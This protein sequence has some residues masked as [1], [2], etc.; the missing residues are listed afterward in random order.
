MAEAHSRFGGS[1]AA[2]YM[3]C[4]G[5]VALNAT[6]PS[7]PPSRYALEGNYVHEWAALLLNDG[8][9]SA[10][11]WVGEMLPYDQRMKYLPLKGPDPVITPI[12]TQPLSAEHARALNHYLDAVWEEFD[13]HPGA[14]MY[15]EHGFTL[16]VEGCEPGEVFG[17]V[18]CAIYH[19]Q[20]QRLVGFDLK[21]GYGVV[22]AADNKQLLFYITALV[23]SLRLTVMYIEGVI[24]QPN[25]EDV[26][27]RGAH[28]VKRTTFDLI[29]LHTFL[30]D[31]AHA[32]QRAK[33]IDIVAGDGHTDGP[34]LLSELHAGPHCKFCNAGGAGVCPA[35]E[36]KALELAR[37]D[38]QGVAGVQ[39]VQLPDPATLDP[40][41]LAAILDA[42]D[43][44]RGWFS[45]VER[46][47]TDMAVAKQLVIPGRKVVAKQ[48]RA[49]FVEDELAIAAYVALLYGIPDQELRPP[50]LV[51]ITAMEKLINAYVQGAEERKAAKADI[52]AKFTVRESSGYDLVPLSDKRDAVDA[53]AADFAGVNVDGLISGE[54][55]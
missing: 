2:R 9:R 32:I 1:T 34:S 27:L 17:T 28:P 19:P 37:L 42:I 43:L 8:A 36:K 38:F 13:R 30:A 48:A 24:V 49:K 33:L 6:V 5:S 15:V 46:Y 10:D 3:A 53:V 20:A 25:G 50:S 41:R 40:Q 23:Q 35:Q 18:D 54:T 12:F 14:I 26:M 52:R 4:P 22:D 45:Q 31:L 11:S 39:P 16:D 51:G 7:P 44:F 47:C 29:Q 21:N 55:R